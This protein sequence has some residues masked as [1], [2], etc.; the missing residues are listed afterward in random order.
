MDN[1]IKVPIVEEVEQSFLDYSMSVITD[2][3]IPSVEDGVKPVVRRILY[4]ML[5]K[6]LKSSGKYVKCA[7][8]VGDTM[9]RFHPHGDS[10]IYGALVGISQPWNMRYPLID[11]HGNN[12]SRDGDGPAAMRYTECRLSKIAEVTLADIKKNTVDWMPTFTEEENEPCLLPGRFPSLI[13]N[14]TTGIA[15]AMACS[16]APHNLTEVMDAAIYYLNHK[17]CS[18]DDLLQF[19]KGPDFPTAGI[20]I[21]QQELRNAYLTGKG[22]VRM[23][24]KYVI[25]TSKTGTEAIVFTEIPYKVSKEVLATEIDA[26]AEEG[27]LV[28]ISEIRDE[29]NKSG[30][31]FVV[32]PQKGTNADVLVSQLFKL[33]DLETTFSINQVA[34]VN[35]TPKQMSLLDL[36]KYYIEHQEE[37]YRRR[38]EYEL[39]KL[40]DRIHILEGFE[41]AFEY[42]DAIIAAIKRS[43]DKAAAKEELKKQ[44]RFTDAQADAILSMTLSRLA[45]MERIQIQSELVDKVE[46]HVLIFNR[47]NNSEIFTEDLAK[48]LTDFKVQYGDERRTEIISIEVTKEEKEVAQITPEDC[49]VILTEAGNIKRITTTAFKRQRRNGK[50]VKS[51]DDI[52]KESITTNTIDVLLGFTNYGRV[53]RLPVDSIPAGTISSRGVS[54]NS[55]VSMEPGESCVTIAS[56]VRDRGQTQRFVWFATKKGL[57][58]KTNLDEYGNLKRKGGLQ[59]LG[60]REGDSLVSVWIHENSHI[61]MVTE[62]GMSIRFDGTSIA[63]TGRTAAGVQGIKLGISDNVAFAC[64]IESTPGERLLV[65]WES[66]LGKKIDTNDFICQIRAGKG[67]KLGGAEVSKI[68]SGVTIRDDSMVLVSGET[69]SIVLAVTDIKLG[70]RTSTPVKLIKDNKIKSIARV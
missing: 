52:T 66:G 5:D 69:S 25:E 36:I 43:A 1:I 38:N 53:Y 39:K 2:R 16:F 27:K 50:G 15:V 62:E 60:L 40:A 23:R 17:G 42:I 18:V 49:V 55:L 51:Q 29:S 30:V 28:G 19:V 31:R 21:N 68:R 45:N 63:P 22:R 12:G 7:T 48:E 37:V 61:L 9:S 33:T 35:K 54:I 3:A 13:C 56:M 67:A 24:A 26:L 41:K 14:G 11:F 65:V 4:D 59:A 44:W 57:I 46:Q 34:L 70:N 6:G 58:K 64:P 10:S 32:V 47:L 8:P 20:I